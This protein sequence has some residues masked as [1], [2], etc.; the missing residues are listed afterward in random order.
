MSADRIAAAKAIDAFLV[1]IGRTESDLKGTGARVADAFLDDLCAG[2]A[3][4]TKKLLEGSALPMTTSNVVAVRDVP[5]MTMCPH[6]LLLA[7]GTADVAFAPAGKAVGIG[8][9][10]ALVDAHARRLTL[11]ETI[12]DAVVDDVTAV[13]APAW[14]VCKISLAHG[15]M[16]ARGGRAVGSHVETLAFRGSDVVAAHTAVG[17]GKP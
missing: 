6:H 5:L 15:C 16:V 10:A 13:L 3:V 2:Y 7:M 17:W 8:T 14:V 1:A 12:G 4:D 9:L 11:Q